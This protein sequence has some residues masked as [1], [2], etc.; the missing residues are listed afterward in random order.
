MRSKFKLAIVL[1]SPFTLYRILKLSRLPKGL[2]AIFRDGTHGALHCGSKLINHSFTPDT[3][4]RQAQQDVTGCSP[5]PFFLIFPEEYKEMT[6]AT[7]YWIV[8]MAKTLFDVKLEIAWTGSDGAESFING[9]NMIWSHHYKTLVS[10]LNCNF[11]MQKNLAC[12]TN[13]RNKLKGHC[14]TESV[15]SD[16]LGQMNNL[17]YCP[18][19]AM[20]ERCL[21]L[22]LEGWEASG[23]DNESVKGSPIKYVKD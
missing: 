10:T 2:R 14:K 19:K 4:W 22:V 7:D 8:N 17:Q 6:M 21:E 3:Q 18:T 5:I 13:D 1:F 11:H 12:K 20:F 16:G 9:C 15:K 23:E